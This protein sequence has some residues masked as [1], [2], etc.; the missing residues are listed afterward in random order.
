[1]TDVSR[2]LKWSDSLFVTE[3]IATLRFKHMSHHFM[4]PSDFSRHL[5]HKGTA[6]CSRCGAASWMNKRIRVRVSLMCLPILYSVLVSILRSG[7]EI[8]E[9]FV[10]ITLLLQHMNVSLLSEHCW[11][12]FDIESLS[13]FATSNYLCK[14]GHSRTWNSL[15][16]ALCCLLLPIYTR[17]FT[18]ISALWGSFVLSLAA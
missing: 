2:H 15:S 14:L 8:K 10:N 3:A 7:F 12:F 5:C 6:L 16:S 1:V 4:Q 13:V 17:A 11:T 9:C 18:N